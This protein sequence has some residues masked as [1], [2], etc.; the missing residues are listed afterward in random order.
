MTMPSPAAAFNMTNNTV[1]DEESQSYVPA[2][3]TPDL[4]TFVMPVTYKVELEKAAPG[5]TTAVAQAQMPGENWTDTLVRILPNLTMGV[6]QIQLMQINTDRARKGLPPLDAQAYSGAYVNV[7]LDPNTQRLV[8]YAG[9][10]ILALFVLNMAT[11][12]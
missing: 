8:T 12:K 3:S 2:V 1:W 9:L 7:G 11:R 10:G 4:S 5:V 6:Q